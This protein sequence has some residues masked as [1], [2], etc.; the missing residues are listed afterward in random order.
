[1]FD[2]LLCAVRVHVSG[3]KSFLQCSAHVFYFTLIVA[4][5]FVVV[6][7]SSMSHSYC[8]ILCVFFILPFKAC[9]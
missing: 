8:W 9:L 1:M 2:F 7:Y 5:D 6:E 4:L 3:T